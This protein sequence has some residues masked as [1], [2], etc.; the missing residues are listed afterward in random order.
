MSA[1]K[2]TIKTPNLSLFLGRRNTGKSTLMI[3]L[4]R[5]LC[6]A[7]KFAWVRVYS[8]TA[9]TGVWGAIVGHEHV[10]DTFDTEEL[11]AI[12]EAQASIKSRG[13]DCQGCIILDDALGSVSFQDSLWTRIACAGRHYGLTV[14]ISAQHLFKLPPVIR[15]NADYTYVLGV[16]P[17]RVVKSLWEE[18]GGLGLDLPAFR[19]RVAAAVREF[20]ALVIDSHDQKTPLKNIRAP[21][22]PTP[23]RLQQ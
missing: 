7:Q 20:G 16:Q 3:H 23:F 10:F 13:G 21:S 15:S 12:L 2:H 5:T 4:L 18:G 9:F 11:E 19:E 17:E 6:R 8:P 14:W 22:R 1:A